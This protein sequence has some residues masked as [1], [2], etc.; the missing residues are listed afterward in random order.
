MLGEEVYHRLGRHDDERQPQRLKALVHGHHQADLTE[1]RIQLPGYRHGLPS[2]EILEFPGDNHRVDPAQFDGGV[3]QSRR[4]EPHGPIPR[5]ETHPVI[6][7]EHLELPPERVQLAGVNSTQCL[8]PREFGI[9]LAQFHLPRVRRQRPDAFLL[10][11][12]LVGGEGRE[13]GGGGGG[14]GERATRDSFPPPRAHV[15]ASTEATARF[16][17]GIATEDRP[18]G[19]RRRRRRRFVGW[20]G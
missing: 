4:A 14:G 20:G 18:C 10:H 2:H 9:E 11:P 8:Q 1:R 7:T 15:S 13:G 17:P 16:R 3:A 6:P 19:E 5:H 12:F